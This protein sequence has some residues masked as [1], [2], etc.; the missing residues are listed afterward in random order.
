[1]HETGR[2]TVTRRAL[3]GVIATAAVVRILFVLWAWSGRDVNPRMGMSQMDIRAGYAL[4]AGY[5]YVTGTGPAR[6]W[7][8]DLDAAIERG[9]LAPPPEAAPEEVRAHLRPELIHPPGFPLAVAGAFR[10]F[11]W[12]ADRPLEAIGVVLDTVAAGIVLLFATRA[13][14]RRVGVLSGCLY[15]LFPP[16]GYW[17]GA[18]KSVDGWMSLFVAGTVAALLQ[19]ATA[20]SRRRILWSLVAGGLLGLAGWLRPD[21]LLVP[22]ALAIPLWLMTRRVREAVRITGTVMATA[23]LVLLPWAWRNHRVSGRW[24]FTSTSVGGTLVNGLGEFTNPWGFGQ[25]DADRGREAAAMG[26]DSAWG[27]EADLRFR[28]MFWRSVRERPGAFLAIAIRKLPFALATPYSWGY[29]NPARTQTFE[30]AMV[31]RGKDRYAVALESP[32]YVLAAYWDRAAMALVALFGTVCAALLIWWERAR[33]G[34]AF[35]VVGPHVYSI[36][37]HVTSLLGDR[38]L[39]PS[40]FCWLIAIAYAVDRLRPASTSAMA[41]RTRAIS[42]SRLS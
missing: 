28:E 15:A 35:L 4:G 39:L 22:V 41:S 33:I 10:I 18:S 13:Y 19:A 14:G 17:A 16:L 3:A 40:A 30:H 8:D 21:Y 37:V 42:A 24:V 6:D 7:L 38:L 9:G 12:R 36:A 5:G 34:L 27:P 20:E 26:L 2:R 11:G 25:T 23:L 32:G 29:L 1:M 31:E